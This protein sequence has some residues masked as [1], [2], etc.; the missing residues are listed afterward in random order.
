MN[1]ELF[2]YVHYKSVTHR[3]GGGRCRHTFAGFHKNKDGMGWDKIFNGMRWDG[4]KSKKFWNGMGW[5]QNF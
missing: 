1:I 3:D 2:E 4:V 5:G